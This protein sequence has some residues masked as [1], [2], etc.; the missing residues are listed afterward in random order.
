M[1]ILVI[2]AFGDIRPAEALRLDWSEFNFRRREIK[3][4]AKKSKTAK[5]QERPVL[6][7][8]HALWTPLEV[9]GRLREHFPD[10]RPLASGLAMYHA[11]HGPAEHADNP[12]CTFETAVQR[13]A[14]MAGPSIHTVQKL[15]PALVAAKLLRVT[16][17][18]RDGRGLGVPNLYTLLGPESAGN[19]THSL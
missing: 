10:T 15:L 16:R 12:G 14:D 11:L 7:G 18:T 4:T 1:P 8:E 19:L 6:E 13:L 17:P 2:G 5:R 3:V 9:L